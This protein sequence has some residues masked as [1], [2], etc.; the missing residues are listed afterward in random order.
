MPCT[1][2][3]RDLAAYGFNFVNLKFVLNK[4]ASLKF[5]CEILWGKLFI[6]V[7]VDVV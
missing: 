6:I 4:Y 2:M 7:I 1:V 5:R 3:F